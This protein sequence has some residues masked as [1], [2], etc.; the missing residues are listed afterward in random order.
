MMS[1]DQK[2]CENP[3]K[4][5]KKQRKRAKNTEKAKNG[6]KWPFLK[7]PPTKMANI[8]NLGS[9]N[10]IELKF[11]SPQMV[12][13]WVEIFVLGRGDVSEWVSEWTL[14]DFTDVTK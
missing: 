7:K 5:P 10:I 12:N 2:I 14:V 9:P 1:P 3:Q 6:Q 8:K 4:R 11:R 13:F